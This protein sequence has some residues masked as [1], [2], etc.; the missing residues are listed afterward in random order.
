MNVLALC[1]GIGGIEIGLKII[2]EDF[3]VVGYVEREAFSARVLVKAIRKGLLDPAVVFTDLE[4]F[5]GRPFRDKVDFVVAGFPC[6]P[7]SQAGSRE[8]PTKH[9]EWIWPEIVRI[10]REVEPPFV[11]LENVRGLLVRGMGRILGDLADLRFNAEWALFSCAG[12]GGLHIRERIF[13]LAYADRGRIWIESRRR[14]G[15]DWPGPPVVGDNGAAELL[16]DTDRRRREGGGIPEPSWVEG[17]AGNII[18]RRDRI[19]GIGPTAP[20]PT[21]EV[22]S[23]ICRMVNGFPGRLDRLRSLGNAVVPIVAAK[24][25]CSLWDRI[26]NGED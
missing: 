26:G 16:A 11:F 25:F 5:D 24:A 17:E 22:E 21:W 20:P 18:N 9:D 23:P 15:K 14:H 13:I 8:C 12:A 1:A 2:R 3:V 4:S 7:V 10:I 6:A 19:R